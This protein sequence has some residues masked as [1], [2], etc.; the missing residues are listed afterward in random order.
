MDAV[1]YIDVEEHLHVRQAVEIEAAG[2]TF[3]SHDLLPFW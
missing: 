1:A 2:I 3:R